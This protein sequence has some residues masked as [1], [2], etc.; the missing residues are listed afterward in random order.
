MSVS[1]SCGVWG[2]SRS[3]SSLRTTWFGLLFVAVWA[4][5]V[6]GCGG[7]DTNVEPTPTPDSGVDAKK[8]TGGGTGGTGGTGGGSIDSGKD[9]NVQPDATPD[10]DGGTV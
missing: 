5:F 1:A 9:Q 10:G 3:I 4:L 8:D 7:D 6:T 2:S